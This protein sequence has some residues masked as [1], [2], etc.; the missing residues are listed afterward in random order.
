MRYSQL[1]L[2]FFNNNNALELKSCFD[3]KDKV[4]RT[5]SNTNLTD[6]NIDIKGRDK[7]NVL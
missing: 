6:V 5:N 1:A 3:T 7:T 2:S 4:K